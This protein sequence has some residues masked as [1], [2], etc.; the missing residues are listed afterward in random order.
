V[1]FLD[2]RDDQAALERDAERRRT[3]EK[4]AKIFRENAI[5]S[6]SEQSLPRVGSG[7]SVL[8]IQTTEL[9][10]DEGDKKTCEAKKRRGDDAARIAHIDTSV[11]SSSGARNWVH[12]LKGGTCALT[13]LPHLDTN[14]TFDLIIGSDLLYDSTHCAPLAAC[15]ARRLEKTQKARAHV[16]LAVRRGALIA[17]LC[18]CARN[19]W[20]LRFEVRALDVFEEERELL[21][22]H[23]G[24]HIAREETPGAEAWRV[25]GGETFASGEAPLLFCSSSIFDDDDGADAFSRDDGRRVESL[26]SLESLEGLEGLE[27][28]QGLETEMAKLE[29]R[30]A[31]VSFRWFV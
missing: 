25:R 12:K 13:A 2:W 28:L 5:P 15:L 9:R 1:A 21:A 10:S 30:V 17:R 26:E 27:G 14:R 24:G 19:R 11:A 29:G 23:Q 4:R 7:T 16:V 8:E 31:M 6:D 3:E 20:G 18:V 22:R